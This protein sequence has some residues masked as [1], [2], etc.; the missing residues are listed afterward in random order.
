MTELEPFSESGESVVLPGTGTVVDLSDP[1]AATGALEDLR[2]LESLVKEAK[3]IVTRSIV[4]HGRHT[5]GLTFELPDGRKVEISDR[6]KIEYDA[7]AIEEELREAGMPEESI[8][9][10]VKETLVKTV[11]AVEAKKA[12]R[13][14]PDY[15]A[16]I[17]RNKTEVPSNPSI[18]IRRR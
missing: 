17:E 7:E 4:W 2:Q 8:A 16:I 15:A 9:R 10:I 14:N 11:V 3:G 6:P 5:G 13:A 1:V 18:S 12:A